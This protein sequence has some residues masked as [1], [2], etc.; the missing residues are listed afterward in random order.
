MLFAW[1]KA[2]S[3]KRKIDAPSLIYATS[4][5][6]ERWELNIAATLTRRLFFGEML[7]D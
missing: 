4:L 5:V 3:E 2:D 1:K 6:H 7:K